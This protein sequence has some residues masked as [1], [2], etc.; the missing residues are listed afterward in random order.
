MHPESTR[1]RQLIPPL[2]VIALLASVLLALTPWR[3]LGLVVPALYLLVLGTGTVGVL[4]KT[5]DSAAFGFPLA[6]ATMH[7]TWGIGFLAGR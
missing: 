5:R 3:A 1:L 7:V 4:F 6:V 2:F